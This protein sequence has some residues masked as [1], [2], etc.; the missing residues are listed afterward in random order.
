MRRRTSTSRSLRPSGAEGRGGRRGAAANEARTSCAKSLPA[1]EAAARSMSGWTAG[2]S[3]TKSRTARAGAASSRARCI[4]CAAAS[5][6]PRLAS[7]SA[8]TMSVSTCARRRW[9]RTACRRISSRSASQSSKRPFSIITRAAMRSDASQW[10]PAMR[11]VSQ[12]RSFST[13]CPPRSHVSTA[14]RSARSPFACQR[15]NRMMFMS[16]AASADQIAFE[17]VLRT[18]RTASPAACIA[19]SQ[20]PAASET[21]ASVRADSKSPSI[22]PRRRAPRPVRRTRARRRDRSTSSARWRA[23]R[24]AAHRAGVLH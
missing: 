6:R 4:D 1:S 23:R 18:E 8:R 10:K 16:A 7:R 15:R 24:A 21:R 19:V 9:V 20:S 12:L 14:A 22:T 11:R 2:P 17:P 3:S 5:K 13:T